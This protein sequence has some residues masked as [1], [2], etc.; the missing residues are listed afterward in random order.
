MRRRGLTRYE[1]ADA[2]GLARR[3][4]DRICYN[5]DPPN[6]KTMSKLRALVD[7]DSIDERQARVEHYARL[8]EERGWIFKPPLP[9][10][11]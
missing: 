5:G 1:I 10:D 9:D 3:T 7:G 2:A 6:G 4:I 8:V 11:E